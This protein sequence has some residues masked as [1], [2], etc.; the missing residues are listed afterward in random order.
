MEQAE[1]NKR[2]QSRIENSFTNQGMSVDVEIAD[3]TGYHHEM[4]ITITIQ[5]I[6]QFVYNAYYDQLGMREGEFA[7]GELDRYLQILRGTWR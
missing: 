7:E 3:E 6:K 4:E 2:L 5:G 1:Y